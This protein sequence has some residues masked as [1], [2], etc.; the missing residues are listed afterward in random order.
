M[1]NGN[2]LIMKVR[3]VAGFNPEDFAKTSISSGEAKKYL[4]INAQICWFWLKFP[5]GKIDVDVVEHN[6]NF[7][8]A[9]CKLYVNRLD[10]ESAY[11]SK[12]SA[13]FARIDGRE[14]TYAYYERAQTSAMGRALRFAMFGSQFDFAGDN[15]PVGFV[16]LNDGL[17]FEVSDVVKPT[18]TPMSAK[19]PVQPPVFVTEVAQKPV[20]VEDREQ[21]ALPVEPTKVETQ[22][23]SV[24]QAAPVAVPEQPKPK[25]EPLAQGA[26][27]RTLEEAMNTVV[28]IPRFK[29]KTFSEVLSEEGN[30][31]IINWIETTGLAIIDSATRVAAQIIKQASQVEAQ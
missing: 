11:I 25:V 20:Y 15:P 17:P 23:V 29:G 16:D 30:E 4:P 2:E 10:P 6:A 28:S 31:N 8:T 26:I 18:A 9:V 7:A 1:S 12:A 14:E 13:K 5:D 21:V 24:I 3:E 19:P 27:P 22:Q